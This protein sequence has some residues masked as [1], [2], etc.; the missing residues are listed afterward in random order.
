MLF[1]GIA[2]LEMYAISC[3][4]VGYFVFSP[5]HDILRIK[6]EPCF[7]VQLT[8]MLAFPIFFQLAYAILNWSMPDIA[9]SFRLG[10]YV[11]TT[12]ILV[13]TVIW[14]YG[15]RI[16]WRLN[17]RSWKKRLTFLGVTMPVGVSV[18]G[19]A[20]PYVF[21]CQTP[22]HFLARLAVLFGTALLVRLTGTW[23]SRDIPM[24][25]LSAQ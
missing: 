19:L 13:S 1:A 16:L 6:P 11:S 25:E 10:V 15:V 23:V 18:S 14:I 22:H 17:T 9:W 8:D 21:I 12:F 24:N 5:L 7:K 3:L 2:I 20:M 4:A